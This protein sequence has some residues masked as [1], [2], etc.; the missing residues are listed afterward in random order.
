MI[1]VSAVHAR[2]AGNAIIVMRNTYLNQRLNQCLVSIQYI[3]SI[4]P[5][6]VQVEYVGIVVLLVGDVA[7]ALDVDLVTT[8]PVVLLNVT[9]AVE[10]GGEQSQKYQ[11]F[12]SQNTNR[13][14]CRPKLL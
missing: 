10:L 12:M 8:V 11:K 3:L 9:T 14:A 5:T 6:V 4:A 1:L 2:V 13:L 7:H